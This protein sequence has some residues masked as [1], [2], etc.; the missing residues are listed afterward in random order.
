MKLPALMVAAVLWQ[1]LTLAV[2]GNASDPIVYLRL[3]QEAQCEFLHRTSSLVRTGGR[4]GD[5][6]ERLWFHC[7]R[8]L[9]NP[10][11]D[12][13]SPVLLPRPAFAHRFPE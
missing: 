6:G 8:P 2:Y 9:Q 4:T 12:R 11:N 1:Y 5:W 13:R 10:A 3:V 7:F